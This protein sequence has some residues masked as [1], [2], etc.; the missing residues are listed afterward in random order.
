M[1]KN[2]P[3]LTPEMRALIRAKLMTRRSMLAG[4]GAAALGVST[5]AACGTGEKKK[6]LVAP[7]DKSETEKVVGFANWGQY[8]DVDEEDETVFPTLAAFEKK[9]G[10]KVS[11]AEDINSNDEYYGKISGQ[12]ANG[13]DIGKDI[14][15]FTDW[16]TGR[17]IKKGYTQP[18]TA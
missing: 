2:R 18:F 14:V 8:M 4:T 9:S 12:L 13:Q 3:P 5:L 16:M 6:K 15:V 1:R 7:A 10:L 11:Y 17:M